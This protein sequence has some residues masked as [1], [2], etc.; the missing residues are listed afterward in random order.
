MAPIGID[1]LEPGVVAFLQRWIDKEMTIRLQ[2]SRT[3]MAVLPPVSVFNWVE[4]YFFQSPIKDFF[5]PRLHR[6]DRRFDPE[7]WSRC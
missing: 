4:L 7:F 3:S 5:G 2:R 1:V 6:S